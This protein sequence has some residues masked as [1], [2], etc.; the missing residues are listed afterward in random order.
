MCVPIK[1]RGRVIESEHG[2]VIFHVVPHKELIDL[3][4]LLPYQ[5]RHVAD[6]RECLLTSFSSVR[7]IVTHS[8][9]SVIGGGS[10]GTASGSMILIGP[11]STFFGS[12]STHT[13]PWTAWVPK[14]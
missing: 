7:S 14:D 6:A 3:F 10:F 13:Q 8:K 9:P 1:E 12:S 5:S 4:E 2:F 11:S